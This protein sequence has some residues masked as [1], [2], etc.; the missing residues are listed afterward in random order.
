[1]PA[2]TPLLIAI[3]LGLGAAAGLLGTLLGLGGGVFLVPFLVVVIGVPFHIAVAIS[4]TTVIATSS[5]VSAATAG[6]GLI[7]LRLGMVLEIATAAGGLAGGLTA[8]MLSPRTLQMLFA[9]VTGA[10]GLVTIA[11]LA[12]AE[13]A[14]V[15]DPG[16]LG[17]SY[18]DEYLHEQVTYRVQRL[19][20]AVLASLVAGNVSTLLGVGGGIVKVP[21]LNAWCG[22]PM[23]AAAATSAFM[24]GVTA[25]SGAVIYYGRGDLIPELAAAAVL[26]VHIGS[27]GGLRVGARL[28]PKALRIL[29]ALVLFAVAASMAARSI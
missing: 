23:R 9:A 10:I 8:Y 27:A 14:G 18:R 22:V 4:L 29:M 6:R 26:G 7:N 2:V 1:M 19:P 21:V 12:H 24:I 5:A 16:S 28:R 3:T 20:V 15:A 11:R 25:T 17:G 13:P